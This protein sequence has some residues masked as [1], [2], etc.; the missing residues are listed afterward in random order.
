ANA[1]AIDRLVA[2]KGRPHRI[3]A[4]VDVRERVLAAL[5][6]DH[7][8][9]D[10]RLFVGERHFDAR[11]DAA[12]VLDRSAQAS[13]ETLSKSTR[14]ERH[15]QYCRQHE[16]SPHSHRPP[17][18]KPSGPWREMEFDGDSSAEC[19]ARM[20]KMSG[21]GHAA[22]FFRITTKFAVYQE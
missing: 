3:R 14:R 21:A 7:G 11:N 12:C 2:L 6:G 5:V 15:C 17:P 19:G 16:R 10:V 22:P 20:G 1:V 18:E 13:L 9:L 8:P 4:G